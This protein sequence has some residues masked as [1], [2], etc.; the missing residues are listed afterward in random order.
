MNTYRSVW[1]VAQTEKAE[2]ELG[3]IFTTEEKAIAACTLPTD[4]YWELPVDQDLGRDTI[5]KGI[6]PLEKK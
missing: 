5:A 6:F 4:C 1:A 3:G 2:W